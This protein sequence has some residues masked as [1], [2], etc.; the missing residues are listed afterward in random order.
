MYVQDD[1]EEQVNSMRDTLEEI[2]NGQLELMRSELEQSHQSSVIDLRETLDKEHKE[3]VNRLEQEWQVKF[4]QLKQDYEEEVREK[5][6]GDSLGKKLKFYSILKLCR[7]V[8]VLL[9]FPFLVVIF[10]PK[11]E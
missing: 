6:L 1:V 2:Y 10:L 5:R 7:C 3:E 8:H 11:T 4:E 9:F